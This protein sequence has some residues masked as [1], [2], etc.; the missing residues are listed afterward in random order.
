LFDK[1]QTK[2]EKKEKKKKKEAKTS[3]AVKK[4]KTME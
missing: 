1:T 4:N 3:F 2:K